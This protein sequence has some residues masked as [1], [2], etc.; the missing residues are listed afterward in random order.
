MRDEGYLLSFF[1]R[2]RPFDL[3]CFEPPPQA[4]W[5]REASLA[6]RTARGHRDEKTS[7]DLDRLP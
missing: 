1:V 4:Y 3:G 6:R 2:R 7:A 5:R